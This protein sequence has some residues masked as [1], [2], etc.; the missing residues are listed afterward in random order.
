MNLK[1]KD[2]IKALIDALDELGDCDV[3][4]TTK[5]ETELYP[6][7]LLSYHGEDELVAGEPFLKVERIEL[8][9]YKEYEKKEDKE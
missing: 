4:F 1:L 9:D 3:L 7:V 5:N 2:F 6:T 8:K